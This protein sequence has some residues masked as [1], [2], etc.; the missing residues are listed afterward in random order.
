MIIAVYLRISKSDDDLD[1]KDESNSIEN[2]RL[3][4]HDYI[5]T[6]EDLTGEIKEYID[7]GY[8]GTN[9]KRPGFINMLK[10]ARAGKVKTI[11]V[12]D[13]SRLGRDY[14]E[15]GDYI[16][17][18]FP[19]MGVRVIA[20]NS[21]YDS[22]LN[23][24][25]IA[26]ID[27][28]IQNFINTM[29]SRD[30]GQKR[31]SAD[32]IRWSMGKS[33]PKQVPYGYYRK[34]L[35]R[36]W[37]IDEEA[38]EVVRFIFDK[39]VSGWTMKNIVDELNKN[40]VPPPGLY[41]K[42][43]SNY[44]YKFIVA[45]HEN[46]WSTTKL[47]IILRRYEY[48]GTL[49]AHKSET[50]E[51]TFDKYRKVPEDQRIYIENHHPP[52]ISVE[53]FNEAQ[54]AI[55]SV[56]RSDDMK[57][58]SYALKKKLR[59]GNCR[60]A[61][62]YKEY[63]DDSICYCGHKVVTGKY[64]SCIGYTLSYNRLE[65]SV[66]EYLIR[67]ISD[68]QI[69]NSM[70]DKVIELENPKRK[71]TLENYESRIE[72]L[73]SERVRKYE[74]YASGAVSATI[75]LDEKNKLNNEIEELSKA[76]EILRNQLNQDETLSQEVKLKKHLIDNV[77]TEEKLTRRMVDTFIKRV[78]VHSIDKLEVEFTFDDLT[79]KIFLRNNEIVKKYYPEE[80]RFMDL[81]ENHTYINAATDKAE[82]IGNM[83][84]DV[85]ATSYDDIEGITT[86]N[87]SEK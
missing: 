68:I 12:K 48:T 55:K 5:V 28:A 84:N 59:C 78:Y 87:G 80:T 71:I 70:I 41:R 25:N 2:Q 10:D 74:D 85:Q 79:S 67:K 53:K 8:S 9:F 15:V 31:R 77:I 64:S 40:R 27:V 34:N 6:H 18:I 50:V 14:I 44:K 65:K 22:L 51:Y 76:A 75:Y 81:D 66:F 56:S 3:F 47:G 33:S 35:T 49:V 21:N 4:I 73:K 72:L 63:K 7:D 24:G 29:Y 32:R 82:P 83:S 13:M 62:S 17:Q 26:S 86:V 20:I 61:F 36:E 37:L 69:L 54:Y 19:A 16:E 58:T 60:L 46:L 30:I 52:I 43:K 45:E 1:D 38:A 57:S 39:A 23:L 11:I 42:I